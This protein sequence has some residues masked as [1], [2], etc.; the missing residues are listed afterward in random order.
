MTD[1][2]DA[3]AAGEVVPDAG[4]LVSVRDRRWVV[5]DVDRS[6]QPS[7]VL[8]G[9]PRPP[10]HLITLTSVEDDAFGDELRVIWELERAT[11][12]LDRAA[13]PVPD[14]ERFDD[15]VRL[16]AFLDAVRWGRSPVPTPA[17][18]RRHF[19][20]ASPSRTTS[21]TRWCGRCR[22]PGP[23]CSSPTTSA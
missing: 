10:E 9:G 22:C 1:V 4:Q 21:W 14:A 2:L 13:L 15:P 18:C 5:T 7:D 23:T 6:T 12:I 16:D 8:A 11:R 19:A 17:R 3:A 20:A